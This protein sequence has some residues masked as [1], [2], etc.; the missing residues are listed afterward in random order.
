MVNAYYSPLELM[1]RQGGIMKKLL[2]GSFV[3]LVMGGS[4]AIAADM[5]LKAPP[6]V[7]VFSW[8]GCYVGIEGG[9]AWGRSQHRFLNGGGNGFPAGAGDATNS[10]NVS[11]GVAG[12]EYGCNQQFGGNWVFGLEGDWSWSNK[13]GSANDVLPLGNP[14]FV[15]ETKEKWVSTSRMRVGW[16]WDRAWLYVTGGFA[17]ASV[18]LNVTAPAAFVTDRKTV[19]GWTV[20]AGLEYAFL[21]NWSIKAEYLY[22][23]FGEN[24]YLNPLPP[25]S[26]TASRTFRLD[27]N[28]VRVGLNWKFTDCAYGSC[29]GPVVAKY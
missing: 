18:E 4:A 1:D 13:K 21:N 6:P 24:G 5:P 15:S 29:A 20:G 17:A 14:L 9:G 10:F 23:N 19:Y 16:A 28:I 12:V 22:M 3:A 27:D 25:G 2:L 7:A 26:P 8:T 11:G